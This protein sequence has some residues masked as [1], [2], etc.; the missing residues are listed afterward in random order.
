MIEGI[1]HEIVKL[2]NDDCFSEYYDESE[3]EV[4]FERCWNCGNTLIRVVLQ[5]IIEK[6]K[7]KSYWVG[8]D[9]NFICAKCG[10]HIS[11]LS[12]I[13]TEEGYETQ[14]KDLKEK[15]DREFEPELKFKKRK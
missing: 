5:R 11:D 6:D 4:V 14:V 8:M 10:A 13:F 9:Y 12:D 7:E 15:I 1:I 2:E 3:H